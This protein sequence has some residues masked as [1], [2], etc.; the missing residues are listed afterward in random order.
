[1]SHRG[2]IK[3]ILFDYGGTIDSNGMHWAEVIWESYK[4]M[5]IPV[6]K[7]TFR[8]AY[9][10]GE[11]T[12]AQNRIILPHH[13]FRHVIRLKAVLQFQ[14]LQKNSLPPGR[15]QA[16]AYAAA[17]ADRCYALARICVNAARPVLQS[18]SEQYPLV[19][20]T[21]FYGNMD[22]VLADFHLKDFFDSVV[23]SSVVGIRKPDPGIFRLGIGRLG[24]APGEIA[25]VGDSY[26]K[27]I[28]PAST[29]GCRT[30]WLKKAG[31]NNYGGHETADVTVSDFRELKA[32]FLP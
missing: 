29:L 7:E 25:V 10:F 32:V 2:N 20:V 3:G 28:V 5:R 15:E 19:L 30:V 4:N 21:N 23:E 12:L 31:W 24:F 11:R 26:D 13:D 22:A 6:D 16:S 27:D 14:W 17:I 9:V 8:Q 18:L 1:M